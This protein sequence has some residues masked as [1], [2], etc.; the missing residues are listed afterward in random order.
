[1]DIELTLLPRVA[2]RDRQVTGLRLHRL[3]SLLA[4]ELRTG[5]STGRL[6]E[7]LWP[8]GRPAHPEKALQGVVF[9]ARTQLGGDLIVSTPAGYR[10]ALAPEQIDATALDTLASDAV[11]EAAAGRQDAALSLAD[12]GLELWD[13]STADDSADQDDPAAALRAEATGHRRTLLRERAIALSRLG[14]HSEALQ[15][16]LTLAVD[17]PRDEAVL[18]ETLRSEAAAEGAAIALARYEAYRRSLVDELGTD[19]GKPLQAEYQRLLDHDAPVVR[20]GVAHEPNPLVGRDGDVAEVTSLLRASRVVSIVGTGGL[21]KTRLANTVAR[22]AEQRVVHL[23]ELTGVLRDADVIAHTA[24]VLGVGEPRQPPVAQP[25]P[26]RDPRTAIV[27]SIG[28]TPTLLVFDNCEHV[29]DGAADLVQMLV[30]MTADLRVLT[31]TRTPLGLSSELTYALPELTASSAVS[32]FTARARAARSDID[33]DPSAVER[34]CTRLDGLPLAIELAAARV[35]VMSIEEIDRRLTDRFDVLRGGP[36]DAPARHRTLHAV[37][38]WSWELLGPEARTALTKLAIFPD[39]FGADAAGEVVGAESVLG[40]LEE[41]VNQSLLKASDVDSGT[42]FRMLETVRQFGAARANANADDPARAGFLRWARTFGNAHHDSPFG[43]D[44]FRTAER[45]R[46]EEENLLYALRLAADHGDDATAAAAASA[47]AALWTVDSNFSR[48]STLSAETVGRMSHFR[49]AA[50]EVDTVR[51]LA[52]L[53]AAVTL[54]GNLSSAARWLVTLRRLP[55]SPP[56][57]VVRATSTVLQGI[58]G[59]TTA[60]GPAPLTHLRESDQPYLAGVA[61]GIATYVAE[62]AGDTDDAIRAAERMLT[63]YD[64]LDVPLMTMVAHSRI[65]ELALQAGDA[66]RASREFREALRVVVR[67]GYDKDVFQLRWAFVLADLQRGAL[68]EAEDALRIVLRDQGDVTPDS[69]SFELS[70]RAEIALARDDVHDAL[71]LWR[72]AV[73]QTRERDLDVFAVEPVGLDPWALEVRAAAVIAH[74]RHGRLD[75]MR[76]VVDELPGYLTALLAEPRGR[77]VA[78]GLGPPLYGALLLAVA[79]ADLAGENGTNDPG[80]AA[81]AAR[82]VALAERFG[83]AAQFQPTMSETVGR[84]SAERADARA[85]ADAVSAYARLDGDALRVAALGALSDRDRG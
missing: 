59:A 78:A 82:M 46:A 15:H 44:P 28:T 6:I 45:I 10:L 25:E 19:P 8:D 21:G 27:Q 5:C 56:D 31:T 65:G 81:S 12:S 7:G 37:V 40:L 47:L 2:Y 43:S 16:L 41:L 14:R 35:R 11:R 76:E 66:E 84:S 52:V 3:L 20:H 30:R 60:A 80:F 83:Y 36:R 32:L 72:E 34:L 73:S 26:P 67:V 77:S 49:P 22:T 54:M 85:Y 64:G 79:M 71:A 24:A 29:V 53:C 63:A 39:G 33:L 13:G 75:L 1:M 69:T 68:D 51:S 58:T 50:V 70:V 38:E 42:R 4:G 17:D 62:A 18:L 55:Y 74:A 9:R 61:N 23:I 57:T 48:L